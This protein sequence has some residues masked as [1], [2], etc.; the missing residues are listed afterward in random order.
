MK[1]VAT[2]KEMQRIDA[3]ATSSYDIKGLSLMENA[4]L[5]IV[6]ALKKKF[7]KL[8][9]KRVLIFCGKGNNG[10]DGLVVARLLFKM[11]IHVTV[12]LLEKIDHLK[13]DPAINLK[14][15]FKLGINILELDKTNL[16][17]LDANLKK[18]DIIIDALFGTGLTKAVSGIYKTTIEKI[19]HSKKFITAIDL[20]SGIDSDS[21]TLMGVCIKAD[22]TLALA[23]FKYSH[24][25]FPAAEVMGKIELIDIKLPTELITSQ[26]L[27]VEVTEESDIQNW[28]PQRAAYSHKGNYGHVLVIA[29]STGKGGAA[30]LTALAALRMGCGLVTLALPES[31]QKA[32]EFH[33]LEVMTIPAPETKVGTLALSA[34]QLLLDHSRGMSAI[35]IG[36]GLSTEPETVQLINELLP[37]IDCPLIIDADAL[38]TLSQNPDTLTQ[39]KSNAILTPHPKEMSRITGMETS[40]ILTK[41][42]ACARNF[43]QKYSVNVVLKG[44][45]TIISQPNGLTTINPTGNPG[46]ATAGSGD[47]LTGIIASLVAQGFSSSKAA[48]TGAYLHGLSGDIFV[49]GESQTNLIAG[50]LLR[51]LP[52]TMKRILN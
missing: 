28:F 21:G 19:N 48:I 1:T 22:L 24:F 31:C 33:P 4:G 7:D 43:A 17:L 27:K 6:K 15:A 25:L 45:A 47:V 8:S 10:G 20:P 32:F 2:S 23:L 29:G 11:N 41:R 36:P 50:D 9:E 12:L 3:L 26:I 18:C 40:K 49:E 38:N 37:Q 30:G 14:L 13:N 52:E 44:A 34:K 46:M 51:T 35:A 42:I 39:L 16:Y 5:G